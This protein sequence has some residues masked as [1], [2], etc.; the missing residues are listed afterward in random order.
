MPSAKYPTK[1]TKTYLFKLSI[2]IFF[3]NIAIPLVGLVDTALMGHLGNLQF[4][5][6]TSIATSIISML[7]WSFGFLRMGTT[8]LVAQ[9]LGKGDY[10]E[11][12]LV[13]IRNLSVAFLISLILISLQS[14]ILLL[15]NN[16]FITSIETQMLI[17]KYI[18]IRIWSAPAELAIYVLVGFYLGLQKTKTTSFLISFFSIV[19]IILSYYFVVILELDIY[20][21]ALGTVLSAYITIAIFLLFTFFYIKTKFNIVPRYRKILI[22]KKLI[23]LFNINFDIFIRTILLTF[24]FLWFTYQ[25]SK[26][27]EDYLAVNSILL[28]FIALSSFFL[29]SYAFSTEGVVGF[30]IG[31]KIKKSFLL[32]VKNSFILSFVSGLIISL[33]YLIF[34]K[35]IVNTLTNL[36][37]LRYLCYGYLFWIVLIPPVASI[38]YQYDGIFIGASQ[39]AEMRNSMIFSVVIYIILSIILTSYFN[40]HGLWFSLLIFMILRS[41]T[42]RFYFLNILKKF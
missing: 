41:L 35:S 12:V 29:D 30:A 11:I 37:Y 2:P 6:A 7:F 16:F 25:G 39:T 22:T 18:S 24:S 4:L 28:Q 31:R 40:N 34:F 32:V 9:A 14:P 20:G 26:I 38:C 42:L 19:N 21:V 1:T 8:G 3:A 36:D 27:S 17:K 5:A 15:I 13:V 23:K 10:R 33:I